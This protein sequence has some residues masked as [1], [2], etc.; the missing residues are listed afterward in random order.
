VTFRTRCSRPR[1]RAAATNY[2][3][4]YIA[5]LESTCTTRPGTAGRSRSKYKEFFSER[6]STAGRVR[7]SGKRLRT[8]TSW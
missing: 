6:G 7:F 5:P 4:G 1:S 3:D 2:R 8:W